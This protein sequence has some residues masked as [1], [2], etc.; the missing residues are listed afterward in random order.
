MRFLFFSPI[1]QVIDFETLNQFPGF[2]LSFTIAMVPTFREVVI[3]TKGNTIG[4]K[5]ATLAS[6][7]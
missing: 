7:N 6:M 2:H 1:G 5:T 3:T 4:M